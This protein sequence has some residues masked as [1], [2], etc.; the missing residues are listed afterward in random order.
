MNSIN[1]I[2]DLPMGFGMALAQDYNSMQYFASLSP[3]EQRAII[4]QTH[5]INSRDEMQLFVQ[6]IT[7]QQHDL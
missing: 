1:P 7:N 4:D 3:D 5:S 6:S 2:A